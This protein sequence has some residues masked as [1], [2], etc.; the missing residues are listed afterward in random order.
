MWHPLKINY[1]RATHTWL[2]TYKH[3][4]IFVTEPSFRSWSILIPYHH[5]LSLYSPKYTFVLIS[6]WFDGE[7]HPPLNWVFF[8]SG[9]LPLQGSIV[10]GG[11][12]LQ[13][14]PRV[15]FTRAMHQ[16]GPEKQFNLWLKVSKWLPWVMM[17]LFD[18]LLFTLIELHDLACPDS[19]NLQLYLVGRNY[20]FIDKAHALIEFLNGSN[21]SVHFLLCPHHSGKT[22]LLYLFWWDIKNVSTLPT[23]LLPLF[24][25]LFPPHKFCWQ[26][27]VEMAV[28]KQ[29][30]CNH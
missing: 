9:L 5:L 26:K 16:V 25:E 21:A 8:Y 23:W 13:F 28:F 12:C 19:R 2:T 1:N 22:T 14:R 17:H 4:T 20:Q 30:T 29:Q 11:V 6:L 15:E 27:A 3:T 10:F 18:L 7:S 24:L